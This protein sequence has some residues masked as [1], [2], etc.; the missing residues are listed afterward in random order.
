MGYFTHLHVSV[1]KWNKTYNGDACVQVN[2][3]D[4]TVTVTMSKTSA[5]KWM[6]TWNTEYPQ[7]TEYTMV[8]LP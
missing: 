1:Q 3:T 2:N 7:L 6:F 5:Y 8:N 4:Y